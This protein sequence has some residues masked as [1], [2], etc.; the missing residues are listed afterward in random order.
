MTYTGINMGIS[1]MSTASSTVVA[2]FAIAF[3]STPCIAVRFSW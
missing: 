2:P 1:S 3:S